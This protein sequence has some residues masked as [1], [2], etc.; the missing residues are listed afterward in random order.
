[1]RKLILLSVLLAGCQAVSPLDIALKAPIPTGKELVKLNL[2]IQTALD[3]SKFD[4]LKMS[5]TLSKTGDTEVCRSLSGTAGESE[6]LLILQQRIEIQ[7]NELH[8]YRKFYE[9]MQ[10]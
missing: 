10:K 4:Q 5:V 8:Q 1:M 9:D 6:L 3:L 2:P 7:T